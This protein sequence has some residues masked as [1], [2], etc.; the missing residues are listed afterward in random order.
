VVANSS[1]FD[2]IVASGLA[3]DRTA[4]ADTM[5][6]MFAADLREDIATSKSRRWP[7][8]RQYA[9]LADVRIEVTDTAHHFTMWDDPNWMSG[10]MDR[11]LGEPAEKAAQ[12]SDRWTTTRRPV[13]PRIAP[14]VSARDPS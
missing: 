13:R 6:E 3:S 2:H 5:F 4:V 12:L 9:K 7:W 10:L 8:A 14:Q 11:V 1:N